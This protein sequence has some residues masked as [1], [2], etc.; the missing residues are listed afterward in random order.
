[1]TKNLTVKVILP[2][3]KYGNTNIFRA[4]TERT[5]HLLRFLYVVD[6]GHNEDATCD[7]R[8]LYK[9]KPILWNLNNRFRSV[10]TSEC[11]VLLNE[12][13]MMW[14][15][16]LSWEIYIPSELPRFGIKSFELCEVKYGCL[17][18]YNVCL[19]G[20]CFRQFPR[21][22][23]SWFNVVLEL[24]ACLSQEYHVTIGN[25][26]SSHDVHRKLYSKHT[27]HGNT[28]SK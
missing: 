6:N 14:K 8:R 15:G 5:F 17:E 4:I 11:E 19:T 28:V 12:L 22:W 1:L 25:Y 20:Y 27:C 26:L 13:L 24:R 3:G 9:L 7:S 10:Y 23:S 21:K 2:R 18:V 16:W